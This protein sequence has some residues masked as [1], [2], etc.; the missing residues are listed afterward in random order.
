[1]FCPS[2]SIDWRKS[3][4]AFFFVGSAILLGMS[5]HVKLEIG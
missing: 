4:M 1:M 3:V 2:A 5:S